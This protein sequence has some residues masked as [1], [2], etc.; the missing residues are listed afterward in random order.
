MY[1]R[2][3]EIETLRICL[4]L[5]RIWFGILSQS[6]TG[7]EF[8]DGIST[9]VN[10]IHNLTL[11]SD[12]TQ[13]EVN[14]VGYYNAFLKNKKYWSKE[15]KA[16]AKYLGNKIDWLSLPY[17]ELMKKSWIAKNVR[18]IK[19]KRFLKELIKTYNE[20]IDYVNSKH[21]GI[22]YTKYIFI[23]QDGYENI[24]NT[25]L[26]NALIH[27][28]YLW[29]LLNLNNETFNELKKKPHFARSYLEAG[30]TT[31]KIVFAN[32]KITVNNR[33]HQDAIKEFKNFDMLLAMNKKVHLN[34]Q[35]TFYFQYNNHTQY[36]DNETYNNWIECKNIL[37]YKITSEFDKIDFKKLE[38][39]M[40]L[41]EATFA[42]HR[43]KK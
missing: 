22:D 43:N 16:I 40:K 32:T 30:Y 41:I 2:N 24:G 28:N 26:T 27:E 38:H 6:D 10:L 18:T 1:I 9:Q 19:E 4:D 34:Q 42:N 3:E 13:K 33:N 12:N 17:K 7:T 31:L 14:V 8:I 29:N 5:I 21:K 39:D 35:V 15:Y 20:P 11:A 25:L 36:G 37:N 23:S